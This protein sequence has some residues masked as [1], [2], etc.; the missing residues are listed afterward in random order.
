MPTWFRTKP[1]ARR[2]PDVKPGL[3]Q[4]YQYRNTAKNRADNRERDWKVA[5]NA[6]ASLD[7]ST[8]SEPFDRVIR[9]VVGEHDVLPQ[10]ACISRSYGSA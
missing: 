9:Q 6:N 10:H 4:I 7:P 8:H 3:L 1:L 2:H 5:S